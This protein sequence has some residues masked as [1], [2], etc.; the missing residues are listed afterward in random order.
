MTDGTFSD[1][2]SMAVNLH[3]KIRACIVN[4]LYTGVARG[5]DIPR[6]LVIR[7]GLREVRLPE[8]PSFK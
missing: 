1:R 8:L 7:R 6:T 4:R 5:R 3:G 2:S